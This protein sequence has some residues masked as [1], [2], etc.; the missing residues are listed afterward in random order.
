[1]AAGPSQSAAL[2]LGN[3]ERNE[4]IS[5]FLLCA[6]A[7][8]LVAVMP[9]GFLSARASRLDSCY[10]TTPNGIVAGS[11][12][13]NERSYGNALLSVGPFASRENR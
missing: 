10:V 9:A 5:L 6:T 11:S 13:R 1:M 3:G 12:K 2:A 4:A 7:G 8:S